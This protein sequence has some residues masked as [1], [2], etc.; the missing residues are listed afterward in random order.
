M[1]LLLLAALN[2]A[3][4]PDAVLAVDGGT[5]TYAIR[6]QLPQG[7]IVS[8]DVRLEGDR[9]LEI[10]RAGHQPE[11][12]SLKPGDMR[13]D[14]EVGPIV[15][16]LNTASAIAQAANAGKNLTQ[17]MFGPQRTCVN[18]SLVTKGNTVTATG[19]ASMPP[20]PRGESQYGPPNGPAA[21]DAAV[22]IH[23][24]ATLDHG[25]LASARG[26][27]NP[28]GGRGPHFE[29]TLERKGDK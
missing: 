22:Q 3:L 19:T 20:P 13:P 8:A 9:N 18:L 2:L 16:A 12:V 21:G 27:V 5:A 7:D 14:R 11:L 10:W 25:Q 17:V 24:V 4:R 6:A 29:W 15:E 28:V 26:E 23:I 1:K